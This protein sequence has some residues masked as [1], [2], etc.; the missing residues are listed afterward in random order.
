MNTNE[1]NELKN[2]S[3]SDQLLKLKELTEIYIDPDISIEERV[4]TLFDKIGNPY[5]FKINGTI[6]RIKFSNNNKSLDESF[7]NYLYNLIEKSD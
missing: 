4:N 1:L 7:Y 2:V 3:L 6:F 5:F